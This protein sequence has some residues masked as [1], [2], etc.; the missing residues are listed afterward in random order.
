MLSEVNTY[1]T[2]TLK[3][4]TIE[5]GSKSP[6]IKLNLHGFAHEHTLVIKAVPCSK[7]FPEWNF[8]WTQHNSFLTCCST[9]WP[10]LPSPEYMQNKSI[11]VFYTHT[12][13]H[14][15]WKELITFCIQLDR[16]R[17]V[18]LQKNGFIVVSLLLRLHSNTYKH[19]R[20]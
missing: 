18:A 20:V 15:L 6:W 17:H 5:S 14:N 1:I 4:K 3:A 16:D 11:P 19:T 2:H 8:V 12:H 9:C 10:W 13:T 7:Y